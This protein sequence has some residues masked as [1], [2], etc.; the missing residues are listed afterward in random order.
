MVEFT[1][2]KTKTKLAINEYSQEDDK[3]PSMLQNSHEVAA[4]EKII[5]NESATVEE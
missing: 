5:F 3:P 4:G 2:G 1:L